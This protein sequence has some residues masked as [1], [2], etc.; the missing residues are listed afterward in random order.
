MTATKC[1]E[2]IDSQITS[3]FHKIFRY[4]CFWKN[5]KLSH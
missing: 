3:L 4:N 5:R 2:A 1:D